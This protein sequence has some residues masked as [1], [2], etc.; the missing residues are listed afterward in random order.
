VNAEQPIMSGTETLIHSAPLAKGNSGG[1]LVD[2]CGRVVG[3]NTFV[4]AGPLRNLNFALGT[5]ALVRFLEGT[6]AAAVAERETCQPNLAP[7]RP[8]L[9]G[10]PAAAGTEPAP[11]AD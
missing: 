9:A 11:A 1:P 4:R 10:P 8:A 5:V 6:P 7:A 3:V 2:F